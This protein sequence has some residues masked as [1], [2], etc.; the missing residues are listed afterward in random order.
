[1]KRLIAFALVL[2]MLLCGAALA[3]KPK[4]AVSGKALSFE[5]DNDK[6]DEI[7]SFS[8]NL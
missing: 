2:S 3:Q 1:M 4:Y 7:I 6:H 5:L 8:S